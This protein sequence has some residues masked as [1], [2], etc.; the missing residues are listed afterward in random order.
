MQ[1]FPLPLSGI[2]ANYR[3]FLY[4]N[5]NDDSYDNLFKQLTGPHTKDDF[6]KWNNLSYKYLDESNK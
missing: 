3:R 5:N 2:G 4:K 1:F 6:I